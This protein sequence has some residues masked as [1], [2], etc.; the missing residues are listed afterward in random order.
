MICNSWA[1]IVWRS[2]SLDKI[3]RY[4]ERWCAWSIVN[5]QEL[6]FIERINGP[7]T[8]ILNHR[9]Q[10]TKFT[11]PAAAAKFHSAA[12]D[13]W[14]WSFTEAGQAWTDQYEF[15]RQYFHMMIVKG[16]FAKRTNLVPHRD[17]QP[18]KSDLANLRWRSRWR[19]SFG[20][21]WIGHCDPQQ[22][23]QGIDNA[24]I[25]PIS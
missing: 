3:G 25:W 5:I 16:N 11:A 12:Y 17:Y 14:H 8:I 22:G 24:S 2:T 20:Y 10:I 13:I 19:H 4:Q 23:H 18:N 15:S 7:N 21:K 9:K 6:I 1:R